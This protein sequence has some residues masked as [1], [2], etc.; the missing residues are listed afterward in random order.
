MQ[1]TV[2]TIATTLTAHIQAE[3][4]DAVEGV[5]LQ[6]DTLLVEHRIVDSMGIFRIVAF[7]EEAFDLEIE[8]S[9][10]LPQNFAT[11]DT[12]TKFVAQKLE[13]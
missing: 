2:E 7:L 9:D 12:I 8:A 3:F 11:I 13:E 5:T 6:P 4:M 10:V 1:T